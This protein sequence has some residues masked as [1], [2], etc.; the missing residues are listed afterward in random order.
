MLGTR[1]LVFGPA[2]DGG[3]WLVGVRRRQVLPALFGRVRWST[4]HALADTLA[5]LPPG[6]TVGFVDR[7][8]DVDDG[9]AYRRL[10]PRRGF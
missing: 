7:L 1:D 5:G 8:E 2:E 9:E 6:I 4:P 3:F 10:S